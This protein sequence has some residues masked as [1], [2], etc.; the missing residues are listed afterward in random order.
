M[1]VDEDPKGP[2]SV[3]AGQ[4]DDGDQRGKGEK[5]SKQL[6]PPLLEL[7]FLGVS[8]LWV[9]LS[10]RGFKRYSILDLFLVISC[11]LWGT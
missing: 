1:R 5:G 7:D 8:S 4:Y 3:A 6:W 10:G 11:S 2:S 9:G